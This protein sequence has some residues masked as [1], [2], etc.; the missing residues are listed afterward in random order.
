MLAIPAIDILDGKVVRLSKGDFGTA[1]TYS[2]SAL[3]QAL[4]YNDF[5]FDW[6]HIVD[7]S[8]S[9]NGN[10]STAKI[11][12]EI[13]D[14][15]SIKIQFGG[16]IRSYNDALEIINA[17]ADKIILGSLPFLNPPEF[18]KIL[19][20]IGTDK[21]IIAADVKNEKILLKGW[22]EQSAKD[23]ENHISEYE[24]AGL[25]QFLITDV[26]KDGMLIGPNNELYK[27]LIGKYEAIKIIASGGIG[28]MRDI[29]ELDK[30]GCYAAVIGRAIYENKIDLKEL[31]EFGK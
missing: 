29:Y 17:G 30:T 15:T 23:L 1:K 5:H 14:R 22:T 3:N 26:E 18:Q 8:G 6:I 10:Y 25:K 4:I 16:G 12:N 24:K 21:I 9:K 11:I 2:E 20:L 7:L 31:S 13:K 27:G 28:N 19:E